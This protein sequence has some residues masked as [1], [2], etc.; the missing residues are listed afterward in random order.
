MPRS[1]VFV[2]LPKND[3]I[4]LSQDPCFGVKVNS[5][6]F[7]SVARKARVSLEMCAEWL[8]STRRMAEFRTML[9]DLWRSRE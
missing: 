6:R 1:R 7:G 4:R 5:K 8:S 3:S 2:I 9:S